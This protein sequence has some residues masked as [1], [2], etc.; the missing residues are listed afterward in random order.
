MS[1]FD[2]IEYKQIR[3]SFGYCYLKVQRIR[4]RSFHQFSK[5]LFLQ[6]QYLSELTSTES[7]SKSSQYV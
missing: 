4:Q 2:K 5:I 7:S 3:N 1:G 6:I